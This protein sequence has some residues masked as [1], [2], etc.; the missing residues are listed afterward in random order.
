[1]SCVVLKPGFILYTLTNE[2]LFAETPEAVLNKTIKTLDADPR[3][4]DLVGDGVKGVRESAS[5]PP[6]QYVGLHE[7]CAHH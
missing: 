6:M 1:M 3:V 5:K 7:A 2:M 4:T